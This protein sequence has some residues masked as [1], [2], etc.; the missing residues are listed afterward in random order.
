MK[1]RF[2]ILAVALATVTAGG[3]EL[4]AQSKS[5]AT[6]ERQVPEFAVSTDSNSVQF[7]VHSIKPVEALRVLVYS[8]SQELLFD[9][10]TVAG[11]SYTWDMKDQNGQRLTDGT[12]LTTVAARDSAGQITQQDKLIAVTAAPTISLAKSDGAAQSSN[13]MTPAFGSGTNGT[14]A[15]W[16]VGPGGR[17]VLGDSIMTEI[18]RMIGINTTT[19]AATLDVSAPQP[20]TS[21]G[22]GS[23]ASPLLSLS[24]GKGGATTSTS[25]PAGRG[26]GVNISGGD[27]GNAPP[28]GINGIGGNVVLRPGA[29]GTGGNTPGANGKILLAP[30]YGRVGVGTFLPTSKLTVVGMIESQNTPNATDGGVTFPDGT[31]QTT[32]QL[33][34]PVGPP[35][36]Q[37]VAGPAGPQGPQGAPGANGMTGSQGPQGPTGPTGSQGPQGPT[38]PQGPSGV[39]GYEL[40][41]A[42]LNVPPGQ[43]AAGTQVCGGG[44]LAVGGGWTTSEPD[45]SA[46]S[47][48]VRSGPT[49]DGRGWT[50]ALLNKGSGAFTATLY[51]ICVSA[52]TTPSAPTS[53]AA[54]ASAATGTIAKEPVL[55]LLKGGSTK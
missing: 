28:G 20:A 6:A 3:Q 43:G 50:G 2:F 1:L 48:I 18:N 25:A 47:V 24:G 42:S 29:A 22:A 51:T 40:L 14:I 37:G 13:A 21:T 7:D 17:E 36:P 46:N 54:T 53:S 30:D 9:S 11:P 12:Y 52:P 32:A 5:A 35:G 38:G 27:G 26:A 39:S 49:S 10:G 16:T 15:K 8:K 31:V 23:D 4:L 34:G 33:T 55:T 44:K 19:P 45:T 41:H